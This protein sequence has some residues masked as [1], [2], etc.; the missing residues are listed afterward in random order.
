MASEI[1]ELRAG[2]PI[3]RGSKD[4]PRDVLG[5]LGRDPQAMGDGPKHLLA[6]RNFGVR[7]AFDGADVKRGLQRWGDGRD[8]GTSLLS[9]NGQEQ[10]AKDGVRNVARRHHRTQKAGVV[11]LLKKAIHRL[12]R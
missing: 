1:F 9:R 7:T 8:E 4:E 10:R 5:A 11:N 6:T 2:Q 12:R 3:L